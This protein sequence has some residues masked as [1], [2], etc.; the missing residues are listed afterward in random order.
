MEKGAGV[1]HIVLTAPRMVVLRIA[2]A[3]VLIL[4][5]VQSHSKTKVK[6]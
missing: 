6:V 5:S 4:I 1:L 2:D 3:L